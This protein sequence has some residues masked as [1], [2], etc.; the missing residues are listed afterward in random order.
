MI[1]NGIQKLLQNPVAV[2]NI[3]LELFYQDFQNRKVPSIQLD[4]QPG[5]VLDKRL[6]E[7]LRKIK[8]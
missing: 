1:T 7:I 2:V 5:K 3:G 8:S 6:Q 4:W